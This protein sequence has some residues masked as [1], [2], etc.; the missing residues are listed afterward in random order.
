MEHCLYEPF[1]NTLYS[2]ASYSISINEII[3]TC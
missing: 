2:G 3:I 1:G